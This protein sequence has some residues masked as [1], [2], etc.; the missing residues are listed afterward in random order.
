MRRKQQVKASV[1]AF[2]M[3][4]S[5]I[6]SPAVA[7]AETG[8]ESVSDY[9]SRE[10]SYQE[11]NSAALKFISYFNAE[12]FKTWD[13]SIAP[14]TETEA[15]EIKATVDTIIEG[16]TEDY[17]KAYAILE[18]IS[19]NIKYA[20]ADQTPGLSP[21]QVFDS[22]IAVCGGYS[23]LYK[24]M[25]N[26]AG[27]PSVLVYGSTPY[28]AHEWNVVY[29]G[30]EW[31]YSDSTWGTGYFD[32]SVT[33]FSKDHRAENI[34]MVS[35]EEGGV[36]LA[37]ANNVAVIGVKD[38]IKEIKIPEKFHD[39]NI[40]SVSSS[41][42]K[43]GVEKMEI[44]KNIAYVDRANG[45]PAHAVDL[46]E[47]VV[48]SGNP[49]YAARDGV[50]FTKDFSEILIYPAGK[51]SKEFTIPK[52]TSK[53]DE[54]NTFTSDV[55]EN[56]YVEEGNSMFSS[57]EGVVYN[58]N[59]TELLT[60][61]EGK[62]KVNVPGTVQL[63]NI[64][65][66]FKTGIKEVLLEDGI[67]EIPAHTFNGCTGLNKITI[68]ESVTSIA[69]DAF[70]GVNPGQITVCGKAGSYAEQYAKQHGM[71]FVKEAEPEPEPEKPEKE[72]AEL[73]ALIEEADK[74]TQS[75]YTDD[76]VAKLNSALDSARKVIEKE[77]VTAE[78]VK[79]AI[80]ALQTA[81]DGLVEKPTESK[82]EK[83]LAELKA[84]IEKADA[85]TLSLYTDDSVAKFNLALDSAK[86]VMKKESVTAKEVNDAIN[87]LQTAIDGLKLKNDKKKSVRT[88]DL[89]SLWLAGGM[90]AVSGI[91]AAIT[92]KKRRN[93]K[94]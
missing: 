39:L 88:G 81:I 59:K 58:K 45:A 23:N 90:T 33:D 8:I 15:N 3:A 76:S 2:T 37:F 53:Y 47:I 28:G 17:K 24:A 60:I 31:F 20:G 94:K 87:A 36:E 22:G 78:E 48:D 86:K 14:M 71:Q 54:K 66:G 11:Y 32:S 34:A 82:P 7:Q 35:A 26:L 83:E 19:K 25:L 1:L 91:T 52:E 68:P 55:L 85:I 56:I 44:S 72:L 62:T 61:P 57:Y 27:I 93:K 29:A 13:Q 42:F 63:D 75:D 9:A 79:D 73:K 84:L 46:K 50:M 12:D 10:Q 69:D 30:G 6:A 65:F 64:G 67:K 5:V 89:A 77:S 16:E 51:G 41:V 38:G 43:P 49:S 18:W 40:V 80:N 70:N 4:V 21:Y 74:I 92:V